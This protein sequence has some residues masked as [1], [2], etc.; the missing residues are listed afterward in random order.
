VTVNYPKPL[1]NSTLHSFFN[2]MKNSTSQLAK[3]FSLSTYH[4]LNFIQ[5]HQGLNRC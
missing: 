5:L 1:F 2:K 4:L 3:L